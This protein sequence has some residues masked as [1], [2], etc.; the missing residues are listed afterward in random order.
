[1]SKSSA[2]AVT[3]ESRRL[4]NQL[5]NRSQRTTGV[6]FPP[7]FLRDD[8]EHDPPLAR[9]LRG[10]QGGDVRVK[11]YMTMTMLAARQPHD[12]RSIPARVWAQVLGLPDPP[13]NGARRIG[14]A[15]DH[16]AGMR[17]IRVT[18]RQGSPRD[19]ILR[20]PAGDGRKYSWRG[21]WY[22]SMPLGFWTNEW[23]YHLTG[24]G[25]ALLLALRDMRSDRKPTDP[26]WLTT[27]G[28]NRYGLSEA[29]W[30][31]AT[32][33][34]VEKDLLTVRRTPQGKD[35]DY[36]RLRNTYWVHTERLDEPAFAPTNRNRAAP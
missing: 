21:R 14:D 1:M 25:A 27:A 30:T 36:R 12:I 9:L 17:L 4:L 24:S 22:I 8:D 3:A 29:T 28:K 19:V 23:I 18:G 34:L 11:L 16:L 26:P 13:R 20:S 31:R 15:L 5:V 2:T 7:E 35:F 6:Q 10:G 32:K 33:E